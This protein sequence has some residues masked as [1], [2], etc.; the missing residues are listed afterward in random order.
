MAHVLPIP[1]RGRRGGEGSG[2]KLTLGP[3][4]IRE[5]GGYQGAPLAGKN[6]IEFR[7]FITEIK[8]YSSYAI[9]YSM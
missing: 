9:C 6:S 2:V 1:S 5:P 3:E 4:E 7:F 8:N